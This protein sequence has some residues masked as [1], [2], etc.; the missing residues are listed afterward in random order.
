MLLKLL[1]KRDPRQY[2][3]YPLG[4]VMAEEAYDQ[5]PSVYHSP[6]HNLKSSPGK[7]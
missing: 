5:C 3:E 2:H 4:R 7:S 1:D 6:S